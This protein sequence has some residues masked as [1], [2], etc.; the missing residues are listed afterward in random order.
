MRVACLVPA[1]AA[2]AWLFHTRREDDTGRPP[3]LPAFLVAFIVLVAVN[4]AGLL[5]EVAADALRRA[6]G[7]LLVVAVAA[8]GV[9]TSLKGL[10]TVGA[11]PIVAML[12]QTLIIAAYAFGAIALF[13]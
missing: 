1:V 4:S 8:L 13:S 11:A 9:K 5:P 10:V 6:S 12:A 2:I 3:P 7:V